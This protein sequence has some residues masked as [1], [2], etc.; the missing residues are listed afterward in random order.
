MGNYWRLSAAAMLLAIPATIAVHQSM[1]PTAVSHRADTG[2]NSP[3]RPGG[4]SPFAAAT[5]ADDTGWN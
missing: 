4:T 2:W 3:L 5:G 1:E